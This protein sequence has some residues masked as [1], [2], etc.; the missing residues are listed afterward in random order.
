MSTSEEKMNVKLLHLVRSKTVIETYPA[1]STAHSWSIFELLIKASDEAI[2]E[3]LKREYR[4]GPITRGGPHM[5]MEK[6]DPHEHASS[7]DHFLPNSVLYY[8]NNQPPKILCRVNGDHE[9]RMDY[10]H[11]YESK[12]SLRSPGQLVLAHASEERLRE[13]ISISPSPWGLH[14]QSPRVF[15]YL[16][17]LLR[18]Q[19]QP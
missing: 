13:S 16:Q 10:W 5:L 1:G 7:I 9:Q 4:C 3:E 15:C 18:F 6:T 14:P 8:Y 2:I 12:E 19:Y 17:N 11:T